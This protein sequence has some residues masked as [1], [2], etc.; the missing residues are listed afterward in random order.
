MQVRLATEEDRKKWDDFVAGWPNGDLLQSFE[1]GDLKKRSGWEPIRLMVEEGSGICAVMSILKRRIPL[2]GKCIFYAP[3]GPIMNFSNNAV[4]KALIEESRKLASQHGA[5]LLKVDPPEEDESVE[6]LLIKEGFQPSGSGGFGGVQP[7]C[8][9]QLDLDGTLDEILA[10]CKEKT[11]YNIRL[12]KRKGVQVKTDC[13]RDDLKIFYDILKITAERDH[14][15]IRGFKY[16]EDMWD[17]LVEPGYAK[18]FL[19]YYNEKPVGGALSYLFGDRC[20]YTYGASSN[21]YR[22]VMP[23]YLV[24]WTMIEWAKENN[25]KWYDFRGVSPHRT[26]S[27]DDPLYGLNR[28]KEGFKPRFVQYIQE[29]DLSFSPFHYWLWVHGKPMAIKAIK[30]LKRSKSSDQQMD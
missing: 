16:Y 17:T 24:Q 18:L 12:A 7:R 15:R 27:K 3:R 26:E 25:C 23:N 28:F 13:T 20:W 4:L 10:R 21:E 8:V 22:N 11:R 6:T 19:S 30:M 5:I 1:W 14:F 2:P 9:M 29:L